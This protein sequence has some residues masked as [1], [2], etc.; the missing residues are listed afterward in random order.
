MAAIILPRKHYTQPQGRAEIDWNCSA[1]LG[2]RRALNHCETKQR[3]LVEDVAITELSGGTLTASLEPRTN[4]VG[5]VYTTALNTVTSVPPWPN[6]TNEGSALFL[7]EGRQISA[8]EL[9][10]STAD[11]FP[12]SNRLYTD[13]FWSS[14][15]ANVIALLPGESWDGDNLI[16]ISVRNGAQQIWHNGKRWHTNTL[17]GGFTLPAAMILHKMTPHY[18][19]LDALWS[20]ALLEDEIRS[21]SGNPWQLLRADPV[22]I[23]SLPPVLT[24]PTLSSPGVTDI[25]ATAARP[26]VTLTY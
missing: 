19:F 6:T 7:F 21:L 14:R 18:A 23:Y 25:T 16:I 20:R 5:R 12:F 15:W 4:G 24:I 22:R 10:H 2:L 9:G 8:W 11:H 1:T 17:T 26:Q 3:D 13:A